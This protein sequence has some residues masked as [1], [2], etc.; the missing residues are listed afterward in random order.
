MALPVNLRWFISRDIH[1]VL[2]IERQSFDDPWTQWDFHRCMRQFNCIGT[3]AEHEGRIVGF[4]I[5]KF[6]KKHIRILNFAVHLGF[7]RA[8]VGTALLDFLKC[9][10]HSERR[11]RLQVTVAD[12]NLVGQLF[13]KSQNFQALKVVNAWFQ[14]SA[15]GVEID[16]YLFEYC[17]LSNIVTATSAKKDER[18]HEK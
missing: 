13:L 18:C 10:L 11:Q 3:V 16:G 2:G 8:G 14:C 17:V 7:R 4:T 9:K 5:H 1:D 6:L 15:T 12:T